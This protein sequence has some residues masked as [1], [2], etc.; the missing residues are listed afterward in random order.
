MCR[1]KREKRQEKEKSNAYPT[2]VIAGVHRKSSKD[3]R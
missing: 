3:E 1:K 2:D